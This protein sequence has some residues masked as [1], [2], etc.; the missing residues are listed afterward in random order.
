MGKQFS[1]EMDL[2][3]GYAPEVTPT[4]ERYHGRVV[5]DALSHFQGVGGTQVIG[6]ILG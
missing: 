2:Y 1:P 6:S 4:D 5:I 3:P